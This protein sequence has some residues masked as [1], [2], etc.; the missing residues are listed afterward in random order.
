MFSL[1]EFI[2]KNIVNGIKNGTWSKEYANIMAVDYLVKGVLTED[3]VASIDA[4]IT[5]WEEEQASTNV[6]VPEEVGPDEPVTEEQ[7]E[8]TEPTEEEPAES[9]TEPETNEPEETENETVSEE[10]PEEETPT[11]PEEELPETTE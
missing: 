10:I 3:D 4:Q 2:V 1:K 7:E 11:E 5:T 6:D 8:V 9:A